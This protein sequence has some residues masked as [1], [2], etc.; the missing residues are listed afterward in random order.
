MKRPKLFPAIP[1][2][3]LAILVLIPLAAAQPP[4]TDAGPGFDGPG[5]DRGFGPAGRGHHRVHDLR[6]LARFLELT[7]EQVEQARALFEGTRELTRPVR[8][9][10]RATA[11][12]LRELLAGEAPDPTP[13]GELV[14]EIQDLRSELREAREI[15]FE[16]FRALLTAE[17]NEKLDTLLEARKARRERRGARGPDAGGPF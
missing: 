15:L 4:S 12:E 3:L 2:A 16:D 14:L 5:V 17:Q 11:G 6:F 9:D 10:L 8:E 1:L 13:V 7:D